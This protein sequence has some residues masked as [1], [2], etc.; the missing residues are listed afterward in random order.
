[1][2]KRLYA[3]TEWKLIIMTFFL[4]W[5]REEMMSPHCLRSSTHVPIS[6]LEYDSTGARVS[7]TVCAYLCICTRACMH[8]FV[9][10]CSPPMHVC[11][12]AEGFPHSDLNVPCRHLAH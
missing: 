11:V 9:C 4:C 1:V 2:A 8:V 10:V 12:Q 7:V 5:S 6:G 3:L